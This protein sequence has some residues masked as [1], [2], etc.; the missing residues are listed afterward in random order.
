VTM[1]SI[2]AGPFEFRVDP[3]G[4]SE[5]EIPDIVFDRA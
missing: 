4:I 2:T 5:T 3:G 1:P